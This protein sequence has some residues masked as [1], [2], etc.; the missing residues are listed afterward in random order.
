MRKI[1]IA[2]TNDL[3]SRKKILL[4]V[5]KLRPTLLLIVAILTFQPLSADN[6]SGISNPNPNIK[7]KG[8][9]QRDIPSPIPKCYISE[10]ILHVISPDDWSFATVT[11]TGEN[12]G[13][14]STNSGFLDEGIEVYIPAESGYFSIYIVTESGDEF[15]GDFTL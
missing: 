2:S 9:G 13:M 11:V 12:G 4:L 8:T 15:I 6:G 3:T 5:M 10:G 7:K 14:Q 1:L